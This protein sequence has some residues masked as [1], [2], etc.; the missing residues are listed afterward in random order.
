VGSEKKKIKR[1]FS[2]LIEKN[3]DTRKSPLPAYN[4]MQK[5]KMVS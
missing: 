1:A 3:I 4:L 5:M 2:S